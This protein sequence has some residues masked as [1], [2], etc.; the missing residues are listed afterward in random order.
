MNDGG[1]S[2]IVP[3]QLIPYWFD[4][5]SSNIRTQKNTYENGLMVSFIRLMTSQLTPLFDMYYIN[6][7]YAYQYTRGFINTTRLRIYAHLSN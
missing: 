7:H 3:H 6:I 1:G 4:N 5:K 2:F